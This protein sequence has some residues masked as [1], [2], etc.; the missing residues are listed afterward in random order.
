M[1]VQFAGLVGDVGGTNARFAVVDAQ[2]TGSL[3]AC[4]I[5]PILSSGGI[6]E[7]PPGYLTRLRELCDERAMLLVLDEAQTGLG[8]TGL[9]YA[10]EH[11]GVAR[12]VRTPGGAPIRAS[13]AAGTSTVS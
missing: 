3:A 7:P 9:M 5:E 1:K 4:L 10:F 8:R 11:E 6:I 13:V 12:R 2:S